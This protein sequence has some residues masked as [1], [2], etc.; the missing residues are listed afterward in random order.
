MIASD[1]VPGNSEVAIAAGSSNL[2]G[3]ENLE[4]SFLLLF[5]YK[6]AP[7]HKPLAAKSLLQRFLQNSLEHAGSRP[8]AS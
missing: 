6:A 5:S 4:A 3:V 2:H 1:W 7:K 8:P